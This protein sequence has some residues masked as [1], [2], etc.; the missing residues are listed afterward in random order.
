MSDVIC[1]QRTCALKNYIYLD[2]NVIQYMKHKTITNVFDAVKFKEFISEL[3]ATYA[4]PA[5]EGHLRDLASTFN[6]DNLKYIEDDLA[7]LKEISKG[8][9]LGINPDESLTPV[10]ADIS[11]EFEKI[12]LDTTPYPDIKVTGGSFKIDMNKLSKDSLFR[13]LLEKNG[14]TLDASVME[15]FIH[16]MQDSI[17]NHEIYKKFRIE[18]SNLKSS[19]S[20]NNTVLSKEGPYFKNL[21]A[22][23]GYFEINDIDLLLKSFSKIQESFLAIDDRKLKSL[24]KGQK[25][26][27]AYALLDF[28]P[29]FRNK[30]NKKNKPENMYRD[31]KN[32]FFASDAIYYVTE[33]DSSYKKSKFV[34]KALGLRVRVM[35]MNELRLKLTCI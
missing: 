12:K 4:F 15:S 34:A 16:M 8:L 26:E 9:M 28:H 29:L 30:I 19:F 35:K 23:I 14:G 22:F 10:E 21:E 20:N 17:D 31:L 32:L 24:T 11:S 27:N 2:W 6:E 1:Y 33:D 25:I 13:P 3:S 5:S 7:F 18:V